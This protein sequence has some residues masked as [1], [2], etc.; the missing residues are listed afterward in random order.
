ML[1]QWILQISFSRLVRI[2]TSSSYSSA[3]VLF[4]PSFSPS[5]CNKTFKHARQLIHSERITRSSCHRA[6][7]SSPDLERICICTNRLLPVRD[8]PKLHIV[9]STPCS[10]QTSF[11]WW[12]VP[13]TRTECGLYTP[14]IVPFPNWVVHRSCGILTQTLSSPT[15]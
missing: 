11:T 13:S 5:S 7:I 14:V 9:V 3:P 1:L 4:L 10:G 2:T 6:F 8:L 12:D 15:S